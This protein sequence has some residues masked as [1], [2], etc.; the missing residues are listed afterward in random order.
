MKKDQFGDL[1]KKDKKEWANTLRCLYSSPENLLPNGA[2]DQEYY[3]VTQ[4]M[5]THENYHHIVWGVKEWQALCSGVEKF[6]I[7]KWTNIIHAYLRNWD[8]LEVK[9][10][11]CMLLGLKK[12]DFKILDNYK[13]WKGC[14]T[15][16]LR[17]RK[18]NDPD[19]AIK[20]DF[21]YLDIHDPGW[22]KKRKRNLS[23]KRKRKEEFEEDFDDLTEEDELFPPER[24]STRSNGRSIN[25]QEESE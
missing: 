18:K 25:Y 10:R 1:W 15:D 5:V 3:F 23:V 2:I 13:G 24:V 11:T 14:A 7:G 16:F 8:C 4:S 21:D 20:I 9:E 17:E 19:S 22:I 12:N 6:G